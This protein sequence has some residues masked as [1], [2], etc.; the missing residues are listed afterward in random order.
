MTI[1]RNKINKLFNELYNQLDRLFK[2]YNP[3]D[4]RHDVNG[5]LVCRGVLDKNSS[6]YTGNKPTGKLCCQD[7]KNPRHLSKKGCAIKALGC[8]RYI[9]DSIWESRNENCVSFCKEYDKLKRIYIKSNIIPLTIYESL[10]NRLWYDSRCYTTKTHTVE[11]LCKVFT[12]KN[13]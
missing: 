9:C 3:C 1:T 6:W 4:I 2:K 8:K 5:V 12:T 11:Y 13:N 10:I 7:C